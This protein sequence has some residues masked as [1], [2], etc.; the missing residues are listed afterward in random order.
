[1]T[2]D[3]ER[4]ELRG[5]SQVSP[6]TIF[7][8]PAIL[9]SLP[10]TMGGL[11]IILASFNVIPVSDSKFHAPRPLVACFG[12]MFFLVGFYLFIHG[13]SSLITKKRIETLMKANPSQ[14]WL[15]DYRWDQQSIKGDS[16]HKAMAAI[17]TNFW[18]TFFLIPFN[19]LVFFGPVDHIF[20]KIIIGL[21]NVIIIGAWVNAIYLVLA[22]LKYGVSVLSFHRF[23]FYLGDKLSVTLRSNKPIPGLTQMTITLRCIEEKYEIR[24]TGKRKSSVVVSYQTY[25]ETVIIENL[26]AFGEVNLQLPI[27]FI[28]PEG[29]EYVTGLSGRPAKYWELEAE[30]KTPGIDYKTSFMLPVY[31]KA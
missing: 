19:W 14:V 2:V 24:G 11:S 25:A 15:A 30:A 5:H 13:I 3:K 17:Y 23:P 18:F 7:G 27:N 8:W 4:K 6:T 28:L 12:G 22:L 21:F 1:M 9:F 26:S 20:P 10:F 16:F 29:S 31:A